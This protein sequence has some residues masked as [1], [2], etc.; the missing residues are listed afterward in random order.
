VE[1]GLST[2]FFSERMPPR[3]ELFPLGNFSKVIISTIQRTMLRIVQVKPLW[4]SMKGSRLLGSTEIKRG[5]G[6]L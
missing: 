6:R 2:V 5:I 3:S 1:G 4:M